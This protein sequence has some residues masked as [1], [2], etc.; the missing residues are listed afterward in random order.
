[1]HTCAPYVSATDSN[2]SPADFSSSFSAYLSFFQ[3][4]ALQIPETSASQFSDLHLLNAGRPH[5]AW[6]RPSC[7]TFWKVPPGRK[8]GWTQGSPHLFSCSRDPH[9]ALPIVRNCEWLSHIVGLVF[10]LFM[11]GGQVQ[12]QLIC[13]A[14]KQKSP[15]VVIFIL[16]FRGCHKW[17][18]KINHRDTQI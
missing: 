10:Q 1:M 7:A 11:T 8:S 3:C 12:Y 16:G 6:V 13:H 4:S 2:Y 9:L 14:H 18:E 17:L 15:S 5:C